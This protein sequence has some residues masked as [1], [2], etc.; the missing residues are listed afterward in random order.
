MKNAS[1]DTITNYG[2]GAYQMVCDAAKRWTPDGVATGSGLSLVCAVDV[3]DVEQTWLVPQTIPDKTLTILA[4]QAGK[5]KT[6]LALAVAAAVTNGKIPIIGGK[7]TP[8]MVAMLTNEDAPAAIRRTFQRLGGNLTRLF[9]EDNNEAMWLLDDLSSLDS[10]LTEHKFTAI[11]VDSLY[12]HRPNKVDMNSHAEVVPF[13]LKLRQLAEKHE[14]AV[15]LVHHTN[16]LSTSDPLAKISGSGGIVA[17]GRHV[18]LVGTA[19]DD[20]NMRVVAVAKTNLAK[21][22]A[23][24]YK[25]SLDPFKFH[26][27]TEFRATDLLQNDSRSAPKA[28]E[29]FLA[30]VLSEGP[31]PTKWCV[32]TAQAA[33]ISRATLKRAAA[34]L[35]VKSSDVPGAYPHQT[36]WSLPGTV[37]SLGSVVEP[38]TTTPINTGATLL[39]HPLVGSPESP[40]PTDEPTGKTKRHK[41][42]STRTQK[43]KLA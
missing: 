42:K 28:G 5:G 43:R 9:I 12:S 13:L 2:P 33:N 34:A 30:S 6:T 11:I 21:P 17:I 35:G 26:G 36:E 29:T 25:F 40:E 16:K 10:K 18:L 27:T 23:P 8:G 15:I 19:P 22:G 24:A 37:G 39:A 7:R 3:A 1:D 14:C 4:G 38:T 31:R 20:E 41:W 32:E